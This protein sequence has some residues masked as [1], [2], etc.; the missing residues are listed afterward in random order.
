MMLSGAAVA[1]SSSNSL[2]ARVSAAEEAGIPKPTRD[3]YQRALI[4]DCNTTPPWKEGRLP[5]SQRDL[6]MVRNSGVNVI[7]WTIGKPGQGFEEIL[8][9]V[10]EAQLLAEVHPA[11]FTQVRV[12]AD[13]ERAKRNGTMGI[14]FS[15]ESAD[16]FEGIPGRIAL[17]RNLG[18][19]IMQLSYNVQS[20]FGAGV[21][22]PNGGGLTDLGR[23]ALM[24]MNAHGVAVDLSHANAAT[25]ANVI[26]AS[27]KP[28][29]ITHAGSSAVHPHPRNKTDEQLRAVADKGGV[30]GIYGLMFLTAS[31]KQPSVDDYV[32][33]IEHALKVV[34]EDHVG[35][36]TDIPLEPFDTGPQGW[37]EYREFV[38]ARRKAGIAAPEED[39]PA[40]IADGNSPRK[41]E[42]IADRLLSHGY[43]ARVTEKVLGTNFARVFGEIWAS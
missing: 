22:A 29:I 41:I 21:L 9:Q 23:Q 36:G 24:E 32:A 40:Y 5:L 35:I 39:R 7:K 25:T 11:Y 1:F 31:P 8:R 34:G 38:E 18:V 42:M 14:L 2:T 20:P 13:I 17:F 33:H 6:D 26:A 4:L 16:M 43:S 12:A 10:A 28:V 37:A 19:R 27:T 15:F 30:I 3:L